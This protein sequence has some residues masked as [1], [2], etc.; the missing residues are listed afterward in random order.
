[1]KASL[2]TEGMKELDDLLNQIPEL[3]RA[4]GGPLDRAVAK[5]GLVIKRR[6]KQLAP[7]SNQTNTREKQSAKSKKIWNHKLRDTI[8]SVVRK[9]ENYALVIVGPKNPQGNAAHFNQE[10]PRTHVLWG[11][12]TRIQRTKTERDWIVQAF[13]ETKGE[14]NEAIRQS[15][16]TEIDKVMRG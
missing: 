6:A 15:L 14:Q 10:K 12:A 4:T 3:V 7:N 11:K 1:M 5:A 13:D 8:T 2:S 9:Y 16:Q